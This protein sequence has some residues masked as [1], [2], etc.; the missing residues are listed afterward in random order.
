MRES[1]G[2]L[3]PSQF[4]STFGPGAI[5]DLPQAS[6]ILA[7]LDHWNTRI[8]TPINEPR[9][10]KKLRLARILTL[11]I[12][13]ND[14]YQGTLPAYRF[15]RFMICPKCRRLDLYT[16]FVEKDAT[17]LCYHK[18][19]GLEGKEQ[20][21]R[22]FPSR[23]M[24]VCPRGHISDLPWHEYV[25]GG[26]K[27]T[28]CP[29]GNLE[30]LEQ[31]ATGSIADVVVRCR[32]CQQ[33]RTLT[34]AFAE[35]RGAL[36]RCDGRRPW[37]GPAEREGCDETLRAML[38]GASNVYFPI[39]LSALSIPPA[40][41]PVHEV[42][43]LVEEGLAGGSTLDELRVAI[44][45]NADLKGFTAEE[46]WEAWHD[47]Q[48][49]GDGDDDLYYPEWEALLKGSHP[50]GPSDFETEEQ[51]VP[52]NFVGFIDRLIQV[53]RVREVRVLAGFTRIDP[54]PDV[55]ALM[56]HDEEGQS[57]S[58]RA[59]IS[60]KPLG[61]LPGVVVRGEG[62]LVTLK[63]TRLEQWESTPA[64]QAAEKAMSRAYDAFCAER[65]FEEPP[66]FPG[67]RYAL[68]HSLA[69][70]LM[71]QLSLRSGYSS[72]ALRERIYCRN[73]DEQKMAGILIYTATPDSEGSM[74]GLVEQGDTDRFG[75]SLWHALQDSLFCSGDPLC[76]EHLPEALGD[77]NGAACHACQLAPE[78][79]C[80]YSNRFLDRAF[81]VP[82]VS[83]PD[84]AFF[85]ECL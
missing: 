81:L 77:L 52:D 4:I 55:T 7:G 48:H 23:F 50:D 49:S 22:V 38:R 33:Q 84:T 1:V 21:S 80:E 16:R 40:V 26:R 46:I 34:D 31:G 57:T 65:N 44:K 41:L 15:P 30:L 68:L 67:A 11:P 59:S 78:T 76:A 85:K 37:L 53:H 28:R 32:E 82:T 2:E 17:L 54:L 27:G 20:P 66:P 72:T 71:R 5:M 8:C 19:T 42:L 64:V 18:D 29:G 79:S 47:Q 35:G 9:L 14:T 75:N 12:P 69:H 25:H 74:G 62:L 63:E 24:V 45:F 73:T 60:R 58:K 6:V 3:R 10:K 83:R 13:A 43:P 61:W 39:V 56:T 51:A 70:A 36:G